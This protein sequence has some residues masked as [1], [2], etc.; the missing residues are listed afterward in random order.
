MT[1]D[2]LITIQ[3]VHMLP[4][5]PKEYISVAY[6][7]IYT[8]SGD[9]HEIKY[10]EPLDETNIVTKNVINI[11]EGFMDIHKDG[12]EITHMSFQNTTKP[13]QSC[14]STPYGDII[15]DITTMGFDVSERDDHISVDVD[16][17]MGIDNRHI[18]NCSMHID[19][20]PIVGH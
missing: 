4:G 20:K 9:I 19:I 6:P 15:L 3:G 14:Y 5:V 7:G 16:Y 8:K 17:A 2:V 11:G 13:V 18:K 12:F 10:D 1:K